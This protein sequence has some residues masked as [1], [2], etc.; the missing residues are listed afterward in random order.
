MPEIYLHNILSVLISYGVNIDFQMNFLNIIPFLIENIW[1]YHLILIL[2]LIIVFFLLSVLRRIRKK[3]KFLDEITEDE[4]PLA[5]NN[6]LNSIL[7]HT[8]DYVYVKNK[9]SRF[10]VANDKLAK[11]VGAESWKELIG[12]T[13]HD[14]YPKEL[15][16][17]FR[18]DEL[19]VLNSG[20]PLLNKVEKGINEK[21]EDIWV[22]SSKIPIKNSEGKVVGFVGIGR[23]ITESKLN[24]EELKKRSVN[25]QE[26]NTLLEERQEEILQQQEELKVQTERI[27]LER[28]NLFTLI[29]SMPDS[30]YIKDRKSRFI[31][32]NK[33]VASKMRTIPENLIGK[34]D[35]DF[36]EKD[37]AEKYYND[38]QEV[39][40]SGKAIINKEEEGYGA[41]G[42]KSII[43]TTKVP[44]KDEKGE[45]I[46]IVGIGRDITK[47][48]EVEKKLIESSNSLKETN[49]LLEERQEEI[50]QQSEELHTQ[51][52]HLLHV[53]SELEKLSIVA[54]KTDNVV[55]IMDKDGHFEW[56]NA[57]F[58]K[59][60]GMDLNDFILKK[61]DNIKKTSSLENIK[62]IMD[63]ISREKKAIIYN[64]K[65]V[66]KDKNHI[67]SQTTM[68]PV[69][70][71]NNEISKIILIDSDISKLKEAEDK[72]NKNKEEIENQRDELKKLNA[73]KDKF[74]SII[75]HDL[76]NPFHSIMGFSDLLSKNF[77][78]IEEI[79]KREFI[80]LIKDSSNSAYALL[81][82]L[83]DWART[84]T[85]KIKYKPDMINLIRIINENYQM[86]NAGLQNKHI[87][88][89]KP[90][91]EEILVF[92][93]YNMV[94][95]IIRNLLSNAIK[96][97]ADGGTITISATPKDKMIELSISDTGIGMSKENLEKLF[98]LDEF[99]T[100]EGTSGESGTGLGL[101]ISR[102][103]ALRHGSEL[104]VQSKKDKGTT[105]SFKLP[106]EVPKV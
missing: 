2:L 63:E 55:I 103:F 41:S 105:F 8:P 87:N 16:N 74:F 14:Y 34:T 91:G 77:D 65:S 90:D 88:F 67:W 6:I 18:L 47:Q 12:K 83:L 68:S 49:V 52:E 64:S 9:E 13:D 31:I 33:Y 95:T 84:Q 17:K 3:E 43:S 27:I 4:S 35:F 61:G 45:V 19:E 92:A 21:G 76:K 70:D 26:A 32:G 48:K 101:I 79:K 24:E 28:N 11:T 98:K 5:Y 50:Q 81:E 44:L 42:Q 25:L 20:E 82:N 96:F 29:N 102:E 97:T 66:D 60:Y 7:I 94:N 22:S 69:L 85:N 71:E 38:E 93:D 40:N 54:S 51:A 75:A 36:Y 1:I 53:N 73:T 78:E 62:E 89:I 15:A 80:N 99:H 72:I 10:I 56:V 100:T 30:I 86:A 106:T 104:D 39:M 57:G 23:D 46:G 59:R 58:E 37:L